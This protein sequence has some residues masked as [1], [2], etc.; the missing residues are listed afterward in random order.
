MSMAPLQQLLAE[1]ADRRGWGPYHV[2]KNLAMALAGEAGELVAEFQ[3]LTP[4]ESAR[5]MRDPEAADAVRMEMADVFSYLLRL[6]DVLDVDLERALREKVARNEY[7]FPAPQSP[8]LE[9]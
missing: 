2:P 3:W 5:V 1:F 9:R 7:R 8:T 6:A 4:E